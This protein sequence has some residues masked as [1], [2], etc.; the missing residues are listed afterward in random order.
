MTF[1]KI[2]AGAAF[3]S[4]AATAASAAC[5]ADFKPVCALK[6]DGTRMTYSNACMAKEAKAK[7]LHAGPCFPGPVCIE[8]QAPVCG[9]DPKT[10]K[11]TT[12]GNLCKAEQANAVVI[13]VGECKKK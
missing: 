10:K 11:K 2:L 6:K 1:I 4:L 7:V 12:Y 8:L 13:A 9:I 3:L 5:P